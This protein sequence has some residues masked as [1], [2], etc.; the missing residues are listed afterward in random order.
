MESFAAN[1]PVKGVTS[2]KRKVTISPV[3]Y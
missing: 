1:A 3:L 2:K